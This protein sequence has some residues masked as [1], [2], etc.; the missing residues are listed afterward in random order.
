MRQLLNNDLLKDIPRLRR[1]EQKMSKVRLYY[2]LLYLLYVINEES[3]DDFMIIY[4]FQC[5]FVLLLLKMMGKVNDK[6][7]WGG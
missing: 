4:T 5:E 2:F 3:T 1:M 6:V 7:I